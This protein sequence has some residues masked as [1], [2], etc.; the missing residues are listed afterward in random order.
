[1]LAI[2]AV[3]IGVV[4]LR[5]GA[6]TNILAN[7]I[8][9][10]PS[11]A[12]GYVATTR[13]A[14]PEFHLSVAALSTIIAV[15]G[16]LLA[17]YLYL[18]RRTEVEFLRN[19]FELR[20]IEKFTDPQW[21]L[22]LERVWWIGGPVR[23]LRSVG[24][25]FIVSAFGLLLGIVSMLLAV[26]LLVFQFVSPYKLS[27]NKF[28]LDELYYGLFVWPLKLLAKVLYWI[29]R[30]IIDGLVNLFG[31]VP[32]EFGSLMRSLQ[33]GLVQFYAAAMVLG[34]VILLAARMLWAG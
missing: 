21:V 33:M 9:T 15:A 22:Q 11:L 27:Q 32:R 31:S 16:I 14:H 5:D 7:Y 6:S 2:C 13:P 3:L 1:V 29:D 8:G 19:V 17:M 12:V 23:W 20:G 24:F 28:F 26:P 4:W 30:W 34:V 10:A 25:G 18:G